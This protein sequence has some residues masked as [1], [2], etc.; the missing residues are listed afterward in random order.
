VNVHAGRG[1]RAGGDRRPGHR[2]H[3]H[4]RGQATVEVV[5]VVPFVVLLALA[6]VQVGVLVN[7]QLLVTAA[8]REAVRAASVSLHDADARRAAESV[9]RLDHGRLQLAVT[10]EAGDG[11]AVQV[12]LTYAAPTLVPVVGA[13]LPDVT[14]S[15][16]AAM[17]G[18]T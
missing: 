13:L 17:R 11:A 14:L 5:L 1:G 15:A 2:G 9:G 4:E 12:A 16:H 7:D 3:G 18:E 8:A 6:V 10:R